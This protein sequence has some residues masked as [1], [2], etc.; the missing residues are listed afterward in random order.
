MKALKGL[1][2]AVYNAEI[3]NKMAK[4]QEKEEKRRF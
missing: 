1:E 2:K 3:E 4:E